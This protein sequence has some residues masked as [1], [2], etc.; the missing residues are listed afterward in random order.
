MLNRF[1]NDP[2]IST[3]LEAAQKAASEAIKIRSESQLNAELKADK[4]WVTKADHDAQEIIHNTLKNAPIE[5]VEFIGE[6]ASPEIVSNWLNTGKKGK[7][8]VIDPIDGTFA[9]KRNA[10]E[11]WSVCLALQEDGNASHAV[12]YE[13]SGEDS[14]PTNL[15][16]KFYIAIKGEGLRVGTMQNGRLV[17]DDA[18][19]PQAPEKNVCIGLFNADHLDGKAHKGEAHQAVVDHFTKKSF[20]VNH[21]YCASVGMLATT[22]GRMAGYVHGQHMP[23]DSAAAVLVVREAGCQVAEVQDSANPEQSVII[24]ASTRTLFNDLGNALKQHKITDKL[25]GNLLS[26]YLS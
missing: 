9:F 8:W 21:T 13:A 22:D 4:T 7:A 6:E 3:M 11:P 17:F 2:I 14:D 1:E 19:A 10:G 16:G 5:N 12:I 24:A 26:A 25:S 15:K 18:K 23:W 20:G